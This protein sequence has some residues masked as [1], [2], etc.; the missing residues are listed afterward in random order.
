MRRR[1]RVL[2][3]AAGASAFAFGGCV[4]SQQFS[5]FIRTQSI[6]F[7]TTFAGQVVTTSIQGSA[8]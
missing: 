7:F 1:F 2:C 3:A 6:L 4:S 5:E 8:G